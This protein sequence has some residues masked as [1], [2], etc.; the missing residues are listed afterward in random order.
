MGDHL[1]RI[2][3]LVTGKLILFFDRAFPAKEE[4]KRTAE[5]QSQVDQETK[6]LS[7]YQLEACPFCVKVRRGVKRLD[8]KI[9]L[10]DVKQPA[11]AEE[12]KSGGGEFQ[13]PC[14]RI[15]SADGKIEWLYES[16]DILAYLARRF[17]NPVSA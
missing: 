8:L 13:T 15:A 3:R 17:H 5:L 11:I 1:V 9:E 16:D 12:L 6:S 7:L 10:K 14:L 4:F 2:I